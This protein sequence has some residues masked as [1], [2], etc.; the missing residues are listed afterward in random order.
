MSIYKDLTGLLVRKK[1]PGQL[2]IQLTD[3]CNA[4]CPQCGMSVKNDF[5]RSRLSLDEVKRSLDAAAEKG[6]KTVSFTGGE[7]L[8]LLDDLVSLMKYAGRSGIDYIRTGTN[9]FVFMKSD[10]PGFRARIERLAEK[11]ADTPMRNFWISIDSA[12]PSVH[13][14]MR[15]FPGVVAGIEQAL[16]I[17]AKYG[18]YPS[19]NVFIS[20]NLGGAATE[21]ILP[22]ADQSCYL[23]IF[24][25]TYARALRALF[26]FVIELGFS[27]VS[28]CYPMSIENSGGSDALKPI[29][30]ATSTD[31][32]VKFSRQ[33]KI[34]LFEVLRNILLEYRSRIRAFSP[35]SSLYA[36]QRQYQNDRETTAYPCRGGID[37]FFIDARDGCTY[38]CGFRG[39][40]NRGKFWQLDLTRVAAATPCHRCDWECFR[41]PSELFGPFIQLLSDPLGLVR[42]FSQDREYLT[43]WKE[44][45]R[46][47]RAC[48]FF[49]GRK[50]A[51]YKRM[52]QF[53]QQTG[54]YDPSERDDI[55]S[56]RSNDSSVIQGSGKLQC[57]EPNSR[58][59]AAAGSIPG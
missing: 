12:L 45:L 35:L 4:V 9:G 23:E 59:D 28:I 54:H 19:A 30:G 55:F 5:K 8:L 17:F 7:P 43:L 14:A 15:G 1:F 56:R 27:M 46:Y 22:E 48:S 26:A 2:I 44:D 58:W 51:E 40:E 18:I 3:R 32:L 33:E 21:K 39:N 50:P 29:Y 52:Q 25:D 41:D 38:P 16:P 6:F 53:Q 34:A 36:L 20:R 57:R 49:D 13:E 42:K 11:L 24:R 47:Y 31:S 37:F 10:A